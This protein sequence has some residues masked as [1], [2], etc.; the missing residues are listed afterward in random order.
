[1][2][3]NSR[4]RKMAKIEQRVAQNLVIEQRRQDRLSPVLRMTRK[5]VV[6]AVLT[7]ALLWIGAVISNHL[8]AITDRILRGQF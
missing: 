6:T 5:L 4:E 7:I 3:R 8:P 1:M 2:G